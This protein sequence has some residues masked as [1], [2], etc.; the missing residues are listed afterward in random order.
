MNG[1]AL[2]QKKLTW[3]EASTIAASAKNLD[4]YQ[5]AYM[6]GNI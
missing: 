1:A 5:T 2:F 4:F 3:A 6:R